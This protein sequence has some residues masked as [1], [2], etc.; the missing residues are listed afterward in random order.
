MLRSRRAACS[1][2]GRPRGRAGLGVIS[3]ASE[4]LALIEPTGPI[5][6]RRTARHV[7]ARPREPGA[8]HL[9]HQRAAGG[10]RNRSRSSV[11]SGA[12]RSRALRARGGIAVKKLGMTAVLI[13]CMVAAITG[14]ASAAQR[15]QSAS[16]I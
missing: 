13:G 14:T 1:L 6:T 4:M 16:A 7:E 8:L 12:C 11:G 9:R 5:I 15:A 10:S 3:E 2:V